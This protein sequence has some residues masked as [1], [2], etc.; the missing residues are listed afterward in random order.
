MKQAVFVIVG[1]LFLGTIVALA[2]R[3]VDQAR[4]QEKAVIAQCRTM[5]GEAILS[6][7]YNSDS[8][9]LTGCRLR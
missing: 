4:K 2:I 9:Y 8:F 7:S 3:S 6:Y 5:G 1:L